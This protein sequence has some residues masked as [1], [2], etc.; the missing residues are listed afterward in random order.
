MKFVNIIL[1][2]ALFFA[3]IAKADEF[4]DIKCG[5]DVP[6]AVIG[7]T[8]ASGPVKKIEEAHKDIG[9]KD[10]GG[11]GVAEDPYY[12]IWWEICG[13]KYVF[14]T[15][16]ADKKNVISDVLE[17]PPSLSELK[18]SLPGSTCFI[19]GKK[20]DGY[21]LAFL[22]KESKG[23]KLPAK[24]VWMINQ[25]TFKFKSVSAKNYVCN[26]IE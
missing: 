18:E 2:V 13:K 10:L 22:E 17:I 7:K 1:G 21:Y 12:L 9:L 4:S 25:K 23:D 15:S 8:S 11:D 14:I 6:K 19:K 5:Q 24:K 16:H 3:A 20:V 26:K